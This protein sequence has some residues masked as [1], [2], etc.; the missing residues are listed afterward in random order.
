MVRKAR[1]GAVRIGGS[2]IEKV[3]PEALSAEEHVHDPGAVRPPH[4]FPRLAAQTVGR[5]PGQP[6]GREEKDQHLGSYALTFNFHNLRVSPPIPGR[7]F[8]PNMGL[9]VLSQ[10]PHKLA[11]LR[12]VTI[13]RTRGKRPR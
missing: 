8:T 4:A 9:E 10:S 3:T 1:V 12:E 2:F 11:R 5:S 7:G 6:E 13:V